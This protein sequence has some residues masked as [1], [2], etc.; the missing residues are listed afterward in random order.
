MTAV[1]VVAASHCGVAPAAIAVRSVR[2]APVRWRTRT[3][4]RNQRASVSSGTAPPERLAVGARRLPL[5]VVGDGADAVEQREVAV[6]IVE[7]RKQIGQGDQRGQPGAPAI[8]MGGAVQQGVAHEV[9][10][11][12]A[13]RGR[14]Q[15]RLADHQADV[16][17]KTIV[18]APPPMGRLL[19]RRRLGRHPDL[20]VDDAHGAHRHVVGPEIEG[21]AAAQIEASVMPVAGEDAVLDAAAMERKT[22][23]RTAVVERHH[24]V[25]VGH[26]QHRPGRRAD[27]RAAAGAQVGER[28]GTNEAPARVVHGIAPAGLCVSSS[29]MILS[30][31]SSRESASCTLKLGAISLASGT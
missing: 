25:A 21:R 19:A 3:Q 2:S 7:H 22:H 14:A 8:A 23:V 16:V 26:D 15:H 28:A 31:F 27:H 11:R 18:Q 6:V 17:G 10:G 5:A 20:A 24:V 13:R 1:K 12:H 4:W 29:G 9:G 30:M